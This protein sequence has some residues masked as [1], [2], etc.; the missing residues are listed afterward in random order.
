MRGRANNDVYCVWGVVKTWVEHM[1]DGKAANT[2]AL[3]VVLFHRSL[4]VEKVIPS[5]I[6]HFREMLFFPGK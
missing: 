4:G 2:G 6:S 5:V 1:M 3:D